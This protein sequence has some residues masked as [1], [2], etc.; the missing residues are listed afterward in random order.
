SC[1]PI[2]NPTGSLLLVSDLPLQGA[3][4]AQSL[5]MSEAIAFGL[6]QAGWKAGKYT[7]AYQSCDDSTAKAGQWDAGTCTAN[8]TAYAGDA[9]VVGVIGTLTSGCAQLE[10]PIENRAPNGPLAMVSPANT[11]VGLTH[12]GP[13][14]SAGEPAAY[15]PTGNRN[16]ARLIA[17]DDVQAAAD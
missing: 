16:Y 9:T 6:S 1:T 8:A 13:G 12:G 11:A 4:R 15:Y 7:L 14:T 2:Q 10:L 5:Q 17:A 3:A